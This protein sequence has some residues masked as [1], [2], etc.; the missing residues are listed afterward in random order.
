[1]V[2]LLI[3]TAPLLNGFSS[4]PF[5]LRDRLLVEKA[6][7]PQSRGVQYGGT[8]AALLTVPCQIE[9]HNKKEGFLQEKRRVFLP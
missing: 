2:T 5:Y 1:M 8:G 4:A 3:A 9:L 6:P 7:G